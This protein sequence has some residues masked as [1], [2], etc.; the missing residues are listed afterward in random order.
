MG[1]YDITIPI[2]EKVTVYEGDPSVHFNVCSSLSKGDVANVTAL[3]LGVHTATHVD[4]PCH[5]IEG[6]G[7]V[8][9]I[10]LGKLIG[11]CRV[12]EVSHHVIDI[13]IDDL[14]S[15]IGAVRVLLK[16]RN[17]EFWNDPHHSF[18]K[19]FTS[20]TPSAASWLADTGVKLVGIDYLSIEK[21]GSG[22]FDAHLALLGKEVVILEGVDLRNVPAGDYELFCL[23]LKLDG[24]KGDGAPARVVLIANK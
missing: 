16:T 13:E 22:N 15:A 23:P 3:T 10:E 17:S 14:K 5:F 2:S 9:D 12:V 7:T 11:E 20:L 19:D 1:I 4:A 24:G 8:A 6:A 18:R 21:F